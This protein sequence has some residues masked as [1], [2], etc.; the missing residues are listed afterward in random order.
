MGASVYKSLVGRKVRF[1]LVSGGDVIGLVKRAD[2]DD[3]FIEVEGIGESQNFWIARDKIV[4]FC[5][6]GANEKL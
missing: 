5:L 4:S 6:L 2:E 3:D 1:A